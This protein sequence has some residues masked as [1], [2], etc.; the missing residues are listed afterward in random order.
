MN[1]L[2]DVTQDMCIK[3]FIYR[4]CYSDAKNTSEKDV[5]FEKNNNIM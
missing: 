2:V 4:K 1:P 3:M 5:L